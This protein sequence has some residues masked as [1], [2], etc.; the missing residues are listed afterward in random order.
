MTILKKSM[1]SIMT[2]LTHIISKAFDTCIFPKQLKKATVIPVSKNSG[3]TR[4]KKTTDHSV[5]FPQFL[6]S[7]IS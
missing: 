7:L 6:K 1:L 5:Y 2:P 3:S 4:L